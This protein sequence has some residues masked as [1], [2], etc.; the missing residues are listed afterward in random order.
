MGCLRP[1]LRCRRDAGGTPPVPGIALR[2]L[3]RALEIAARIGVRLTT[4]TPRPLLLPVR[5]GGRASPPPSF[6]T[7]Q[8][9]AFEKGEDAMAAFVGPCYLD[10]GSAHDRPPKGAHDHSASDRDRSARDPPAWIGSRPL[11]S[12]SSVLATSTAASAN[13][14]ASILEVAKVAAL[15]SG[16]VSGSCRLSLDSLA[17]DR[18][19]GGF[20]RL[21]FFS[22]SREST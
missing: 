22:R 11:A 1:C 19:T 7:G 9:S 3:L 18:F 12:P 5:R 2:A 6:S 15:S 4:A 16:H 13:L 10:F 17:S 8:L 14:I 21:D 20:S